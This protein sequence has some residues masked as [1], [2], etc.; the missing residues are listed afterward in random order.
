MLAGLRLLRRGRGRLLPAEEPLHELVVAGDD[1]D[2]EHALVASRFQWISDFSF[3]GISCPVT[4]ATEAAK[5]L[6][7]NGMPA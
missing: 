5:P 6:W 7:V 3:P 2:A 1:E 4:K